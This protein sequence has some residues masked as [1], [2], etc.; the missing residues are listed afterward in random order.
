VQESGSKRIE[1]ANDRWKKRQ[2]LRLGDDPFAPT[3]PMKKLE[4]RLGRFKYY[5][6]T[7]LNERESESLPPFGF[8]SRTLNF[9][10]YRTYLT[11]ANH[12]FQRLRPF[13]Q[14]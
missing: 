11:T 9:D 10:N 14:H 4:G 8:L 3:M 6:P 1:R 5:F 2:R 12:I 13:Y 7:A